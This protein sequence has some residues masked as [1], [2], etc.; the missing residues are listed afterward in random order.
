MNTEKY[1]IKAKGNGPEVSEAD[2]IKMTDEQRN[3][4]QQQMLGKLRTML[5]DRF[6]L[7]VH[8]EM[9]EMPVYALVVL[10]NA[11]L[12][13]G[14]CASA[15]TGKKPGR[16]PPPRWAPDPEDS[17]PPAGLPQPPPC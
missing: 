1:D 5:A 3:Q 10:K 11:V 12:L 16:R 15:Q 6:Q 7:R 4:F 17:L 13:T 8:W 2:L 9:K 14:G